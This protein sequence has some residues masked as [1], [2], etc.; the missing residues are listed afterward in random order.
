MFFLAYV[1]FAF[2]KCKIV[3]TESRENRF[4]VFLCRGATYFAF[5][6]CK[7]KA[8]ENILQVPL[9]IRNKNLFLH[10]VTK[11]SSKQQHL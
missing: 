3:L 4:T 2:F 11:Q 9:K 6:D 1:N 7:I 5:F 10:R 8:T